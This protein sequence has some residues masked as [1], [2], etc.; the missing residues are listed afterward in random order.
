MQQ[1][2]WLTAEDISEMLGVPVDSVR[3]WIRDR[4]L[5]ATRPGRQWLVK[6]EDLEQFLRDNSNIADEG[7]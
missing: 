6:R 2:E 7:I 1:K 4:R 3:Q 5:K